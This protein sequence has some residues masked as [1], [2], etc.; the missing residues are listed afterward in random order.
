VTS[1]SLH[2]PLMLASLDRASRT[3]DAVRQAGRFGV[4]VLR[5]GHAELARSFA[6][7]FTHEA[8]WADVPWSERH[9]V[10]LL[11]DALLRIACEL[12]EVHAG[13]DH[14]ILTG[15]V[16]EVAGGGADDPLIFH[17]GGYRGLD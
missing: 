16:L 17:L 5:S 6:G 3:L 9:G 8:R 1:L 15:S 14:V 12:D 4:N 2:P 10:P 11:D 13:G 7:P